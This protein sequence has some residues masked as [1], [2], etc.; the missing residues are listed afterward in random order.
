[1]FSLKIIKLNWYLMRGEINMP[2]SKKEMQRQMAEKEAQMQNI[3]K[4]RDWNA[5]FALDENG[6]FSRVILYF[7]FNAVGMLIRKGS[8]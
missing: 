4:N 8:I 6:D 3:V 5:L 7:K 1:M 2:M